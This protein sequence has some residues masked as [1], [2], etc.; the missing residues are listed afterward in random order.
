MSVGTP[1][2]LLNA[3][4]YSE[5]I[6][7]TGIY[8]DDD[9]E[10]MVKIN[11]ILDDENYRNKYSKKSIDTAKQNTWQKTIKQYNEHFVLAE[12]ELNEIKQD[13]DSYKKIVKYILDNGYVSKRQ[14][15]S[16]L[17]WG[18]RIPFDAYRNRLRNEIKIKFTKYGYGVK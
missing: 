2:I 15:K 7:D 3:N 14:L 10:F 18:I 8:F 17:N 5:T 12:K 6:K 13:T 11:K 16:Y 1:Y 4:Y 9:K